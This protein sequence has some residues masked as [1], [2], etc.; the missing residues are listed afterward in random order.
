MLSCH[1]RKCSKVAF[2]L[3]FSNADKI[4]KTLDDFLSSPLCNCT[5]IRSSPG[6]VGRTVD[7]LQRCDK[8]QKCFEAEVWR[9]VNEH[10]H[11]AFRTAR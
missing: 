7:N 10:L 1:L 2:L 6:S 8:G 11:K 3:E 5:E 4:Q 9:N